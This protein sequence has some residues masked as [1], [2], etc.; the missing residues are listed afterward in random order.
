MRNLYFMF[1]LLALPLATFA[2]ANNARAGGTKQSPLREGKACAKKSKSER[3]VEK[4]RTHFE[5]TKMNESRDHVS[6]SPL[7]RFIA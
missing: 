2:E 7:Q 6:T 3:C 5:N 4:A 1:A